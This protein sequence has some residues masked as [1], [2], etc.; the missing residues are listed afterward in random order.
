MS[1]AH[2]EVAPGDYAQLLSLA[3]D[4]AKT[5]HELAEREQALTADPVTAPGIA[6]PGGQRTFLS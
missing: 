5:T 2:G 4:W 6:A 3:E 1:L